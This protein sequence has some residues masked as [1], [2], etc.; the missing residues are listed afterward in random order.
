MG[1]NYYSF[2][3]L[4]WQN[5]NIIFIKWYTNKSFIVFSRNSLKILNRT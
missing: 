2:I 5:I 4:K 3:F 1:K